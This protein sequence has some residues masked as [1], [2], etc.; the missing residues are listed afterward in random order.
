MV[1]L[2]YQEIAFLSSL[3]LTGYLLGS[4]D[5]LSSKR[6]NVTDR[7]WID[8]HSAQNLWVKRFKRYIKY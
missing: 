4:M 5:C 7:L 1:F 3:L 2:S 6:R 8:R